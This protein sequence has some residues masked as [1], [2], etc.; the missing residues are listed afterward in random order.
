[1]MFNERMRED[2]GNDGGRKPMLKRREE[3]GRVK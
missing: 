3:K 1:M 2:L